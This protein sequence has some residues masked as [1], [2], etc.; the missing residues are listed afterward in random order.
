M[1]D[2]ALDR[3]GSL[4]I[5]EYPALWLFGLG[6][7]EVVL[8]GVVVPV[9]LGVV[10]PLGRRLVLHLLDT[11]LFSLGVSLQLFLLEQVLL[12]LLILLVLHL[13]LLLQDVPVVQDGVAELIVDD[14]LRQE[15]LDPI[16]DEGHLEDLGDAGPPVGVLAQTQVDQVSQVFA[17]LAADGLVLPVH[18]LH[19]QGVDALSV[20]RGAQHA[21]FV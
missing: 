20:E 19:R 12:V 18:Y 3:L 9:L 14:T 10:P 4:V 7:V 15:G 16:P 17:V 6:G 2:L 21:Q 8:S 1:A 11:V 5:G 13:L